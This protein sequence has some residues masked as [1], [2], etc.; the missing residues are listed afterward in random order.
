MKATKTTPKKSTRKYKVI[1][2]ESMMAENVNSNHASEPSVMAKRNKNDLVK[3]SKRNKHVDN[4][5]PLRRGQ[6]R[7]K[8]KELTENADGIDP[9][10][11]EISQFV[12]D[13]E[14]IQMEI[15]DGGAAVGEFASEHDTETESEGSE[16]ELDESH[17]E[18][19]ISDGQVTDTEVDTENEYE[20]PQTGDK[21]S[22]SKAK[23]RNIKN[24]KI[25][26]KQ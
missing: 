19:T 1:D 6:S 23:K 4:A 8:D 5:E 12:E 25:K 17:Q 10:N 20:N 14:L 22:S 9:E 11:T 16:S 13:G 24:L 26:L 2:K 21:R 7:S 18:D 3:V 15:N